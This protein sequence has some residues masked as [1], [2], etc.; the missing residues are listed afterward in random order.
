L[1]Q[2]SAFT[3]TG[4]IKIPDTTPQLGIQGFFLP[5]VTTDFSNGPISTFPAPDDPAAYLSLW[6]GDLGLDTGAPQS[7]YRLDTA[8]MQ[9][10]GIEELKPGETWQLPQGYGTLEFVGFNRWAT[11][12]ISADSGK[13]P[14]LLASILAIVGLTMSLLIPRRRVWLRVSSTSQSEVTLCEVAGLAKTE[15]PGLRDEVSKL[16]IR[17]KE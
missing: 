3:S 14:A 15:A 10:V 17:V 6:V 5:T 13:V 4:V 9:R 11:F 7:V 8:K 2:D 12:S 16:T 1:P